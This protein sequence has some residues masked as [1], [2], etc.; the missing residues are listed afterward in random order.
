MQ[1]APEGHSHFKVA[2]VWQVGVIFSRLPAGLHDTAEWLEHQIHVSVKPH[3]AWEDAYTRQF[4]ELP[5]S[6]FL[7]FTISGF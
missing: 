5:E 2:S 3:E 1:T 4:N 7:C 6:R